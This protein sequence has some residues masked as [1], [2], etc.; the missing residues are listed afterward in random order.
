MGEMGNYDE[1]GN[2]EVA[3]DGVDDFTRLLKVKYF[4]LFLI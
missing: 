3:L 2:E 1:L 4:A